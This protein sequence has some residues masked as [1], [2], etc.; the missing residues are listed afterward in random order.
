LWL[1]IHGREASQILFPGKFGMDGGCLPGSKEAHGD[2]IHEEQQK[3]E[4]NEPYWQEDQDTSAN[5]FLF[6][7]FLP[8]VWNEGVQNKYSS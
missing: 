5:G 7:G 8:G 4:G 1:I 2:P 6:H 3:D